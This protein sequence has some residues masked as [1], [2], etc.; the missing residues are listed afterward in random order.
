MFVNH[1]SDKGLLFNIY[2]NSYYLIAN[3]N[4][5]KNPNNL[6]LKWTENLSKHFFPITYANG[7]PC[8]KSYQDHNH[9][10]NANHT[11]NEIP[12]YIC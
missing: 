3:N 5:K 6:I 10:R 2:K 1:V 8:M 12:H 4:N 11:H 9:H 7:H